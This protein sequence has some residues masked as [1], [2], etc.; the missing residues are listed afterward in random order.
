MRRFAV[1][2][3][4]AEDSPLTRLAS[5][6]LGRDA[7]ADAELHSP[8]LNGFPRKVW[9]A[10]TSDPRRYGF[11]ATLKPPFHLADGV[12]EQELRGAARRLAKSWK[13]FEAPVLQVGTL[14][15]FLALT[16]SGRCPKLEDLAAGCVRDLDVFRAPPTGEELA[17]RRRSRLT[18]PQAALLDRWGYPY[19]M[20]EW[21]FHMTLTSSL[22]PALLKPIGTHL[23]TLF[24]PYCREPLP[25]D[26]ICLFEQPGKDEPF[27]VLERY[28]F[29]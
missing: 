6:W 7:F 12:T 8:P 21:R 25:V 16:L 28:S 22:E 9:R 4:P 5:A 10:A 26:S 1:Y 13:A 2:F 15:S 24:A 18:A 11:H 14:S 20:G 19:V 23:E 29:S 3:T 17:R 27:H